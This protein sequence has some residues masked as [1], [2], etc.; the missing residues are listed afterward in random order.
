M[1]IYIRNILI[2]SKILTMKKEEDLKIT[3]DDCSIV[4][5]CA[6]LLRE[7]KELILDMRTK[8]SKVEPKNILGIIEELHSCE[9]DLTKVSEKLK[10][11]TSDLEY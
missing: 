6:D 10:R 4:C 11:L 2:T 1:H 7:T 5:I 3:T 9:A 8:K